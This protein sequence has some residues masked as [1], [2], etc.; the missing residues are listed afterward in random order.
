MV[1]QIQILM[2]FMQPSHGIFRMEQMPLILIQ[3]NG[4]ILILMVMGTIGMILL[5]MRVVQSMD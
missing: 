3:L 4:Q 2:Q 5:G 1:G